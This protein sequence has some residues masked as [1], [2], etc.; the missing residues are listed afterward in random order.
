MTDMVNLV[1]PCFTDLDFYIGMPE[2]LF[3]RGTFLVNLKDNYDPDKFFE[4]AFK[5]AKK[6]YLER[7][8]KYNSPL[9]IQNVSRIVEQTQ[10]NIM[11]TCP[12]NIQRSFSAVK[13]IRFI[14]KSLMI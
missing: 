13:N 7:C 14:G 6:E 2:D 3:D 10:C 9:D 12:C 4:E 8:Q 11:K 5:N 1:Q